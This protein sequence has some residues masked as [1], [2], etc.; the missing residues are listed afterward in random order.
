MARPSSCCAAPVSKS[1]RRDPVWASRII[2]YGLAPGAA[3]C[4][5]ERP[6]GDLQGSPAGRVLRN[7]GSGTDRSTDFPGVAEAKPQFSR[8]IDQYLRRQ[9]VANSITLLL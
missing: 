6:V 3:D 1:I 7:F 5:R 4:G 8:S 2:G 9:T